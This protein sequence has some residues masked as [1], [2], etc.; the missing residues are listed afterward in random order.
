MQSI[1]NRRKVRLGRKMSFWRKRKMR[2]ERPRLCVFRSSKHMQIQLID[3][4]SGKVL[5]SASSCEK[6]FSGKGKGKEIAAAVGAL[7]AQRA[8]AAGVKEVV[9]DRNGFAYHGRIEAAATG[10]RNAGLSF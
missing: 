3:D 8:G 9:F 10:A 5:A 4:L 6:G 7:V 1:L 2:L